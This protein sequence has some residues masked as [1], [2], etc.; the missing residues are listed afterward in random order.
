MTKE[1][2]RKDDQAQ[3]W[4]DQENHAT[5][6]L[7]VFIAFQIVFV[8]VGASIGQMWIAVIPVAVYLVYIVK[9]QL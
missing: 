2:T 5:Q 3:R 8:L 6:A 1:P 9:N 7:L 4:K